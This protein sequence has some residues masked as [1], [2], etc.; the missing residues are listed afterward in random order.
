MSD[1]AGCRPS[2]LTFLPTGRPQLK[3]VISTTSAQVSYAQRAP[4]K[5]APLHRV[6]KTLPD[7]LT[8]GF[9]ATI[10]SKQSA[11]VRQRRH[12]LTHYFIEP[13]SREAEYLFTL[14]HRNHETNIA[15]W[16]ERQHK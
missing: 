5:P 14:K 10:F 7:L 1:P 8:R 16:K 12:P 15:S 6:S 2:T 9:P 13:G 4:A 11:V 3:S